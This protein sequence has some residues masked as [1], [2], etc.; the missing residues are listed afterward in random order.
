METG[1]LKAEL[2]SAH[3]LLVDDEVSILASIGMYLE[4]MGYRV[5]SAS[6]GEEAIELMDRTI[7]DLIITDLVMGSV[8]GLQVVQRAKHLDQM[9]V[10]LT[11]YSAVHFA[12]DALRLGADD[13]ILKP[14]DP[15]ELEF[16]LRR[17]FDKLKVKK[18]AVLAEEALRESEKKIRSIIDHSPAFIFLKD[19][20]GKYTLVNKQFEKLLRKNDRQLVGNSDYDIF[21]KEWADVMRKNDQQVIARNGP[22]EFEETFHLEDGPHTYFSIKFPVYFASGAPQG[23]C[24]ISSDITERK[25]IERRLQQAQR[26]ET[27]GCLAG[28][29]AHDYNNL[30]MA[31]QGRTSIMLA[32]KDSSHPDFEHLIQIENAIQ[33]AAGLNKQLL[34]FAR[35]G[36][37]HI[38]K[39]DLNEFIREQNSF[40]AR[41]RREIIL[42]EEFEANLWAVEVDRG[43][44]G[45]VLLN[46]YINA[47]Q[48][49]QEGGTIH[50]QTKNVTL[51]EDYVKGF[52]V[53][54]GRYVSLMVSDTGTGMDE[55][56]LERI[57]DPFFSTK[58][59]RRG[60]G[61]GLAAAYGIIKNHGGMVDVHSERGKGTTFSI[62][63]PAI[64]AAPMVQTEEKPVHE[65]EF[66]KRDTIVLGVEQLL[67]VDDE[68]MILDV[69][70]KMLTRLGYKVLIAGGGKEALEI[71]KKYQGQIDMVILDIIMPEMGGEETFDAI[72]A[73]YPDMKVL[74]SSGYNKDERI[75][76]ILDKGCVGFIQKP[77]RMQ[78]LSQ[79]LKEALNKK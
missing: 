23:V 27:I 50:I 11:G 51:K 39:T 17:C 36:K 32:D 10:V 46:L 42:K 47:S 18:R 53:P 64:D 4:D 78:E 25:R 62:Y 60:G 33:R 67:L 43:Q 71:C 77:Y 2:P 19:L 63:L 57:F 24:S 37:Y 54:P 3:V 66:K 76:K 1:V 16:R 35:L 41:S 20:E 70:K 74:L 22:V 79:K 52:G 26:M 21:P 29:I 68:Q 34:G 5:S 75:K 7:F 14:C 9:V 45:Q 55:A 72:K 73:I 58:E 38:Q 48:A 15:Q 40:F 6:S 65:T 8:D 13:Y 12:I 61:L 31:I 56:I 44:I 49:M 30:L 28:G 69:G 59:M